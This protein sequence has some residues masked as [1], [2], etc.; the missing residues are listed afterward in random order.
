M[1]ELCILSLACAFVLLCLICWRVLTCLQTVVGLD[2]RSRDR[3]R[4]DYI[5]TISQMAEK[6]SVRQPAEVLAT[7]QMH[8]SERMNAAAANV[9]IEKAALK[10]NKPKESVMV[11][12]SSEIGSYFK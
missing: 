3:E 12:T 8:L 1:F 7:T 2:K 6:A 4:L 11:D 5:R 9:D 10:N